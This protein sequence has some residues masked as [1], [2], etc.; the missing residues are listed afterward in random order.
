[1]SSIDRVVVADSDVLVRHAL[2]DFLRDCGFRVIEAADSEE[3]VKVLAETGLG[4]DI[5]LADS[6][7]GGELG[8]FGLRRWMRENKPGIDLVMAAGDK[9]QADVAAELCEQGP[10]LGR[11]YDTQ[12]VVERIRQLRGRRESA[13]QLAAAPSPAS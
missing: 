10:D 9:A 3:V 12:R 6:A 7:L 13:R 5:V 4:I 8:G 11:P 1:M 2:A